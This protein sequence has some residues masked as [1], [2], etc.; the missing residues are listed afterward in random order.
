M[1]YLE[2]LKK[3][4]F[5]NPLRIN[6]T[7]K[8]LDMYVDSFHREIN[9]LLQQENKSVN[10]D[11]EKNVKKPNIVPVDLDK[12]E[13]AERIKSK[14]VSVSN[15]LLSELEDFRK[16]INFFNFIEGTKRFEQNVLQILKKEVD[17]LN[18]G[19]T[20]DRIISD[21]EKELNYGDQ[22]EQESLFSK[23]RSWEYLMD[24][25]SLEELKRLFIDI[26]SNEVIDEI[27][28]N[29]EEKL[30]EII[31][32]IINEYKDYLSNCINYYKNHYNGLDDV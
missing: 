4:M 14:L 24:D 13:N 19:T 7:I 23:I 22:K 31:N 8:K 29:E 2:K 16:S 25:G 18:K 30:N 26:R 6:L 20:L 1:Q 5:T 11:I 27:R 3:S 15:K 17:F 28:K 32:H 12:L 9:E 10:F 21:I